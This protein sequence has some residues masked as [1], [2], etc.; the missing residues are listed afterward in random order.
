MSEFRPSRFEILPLVVK[1]LLIINILFFIAQNTIGNNPFFSITD[2]LALHHVQSPLFK[3]W[4]IITY[5]F[6]HAGIWHL[7]LNMFGL[8]MFGARLESMWGP[9]RFLTFYFLCGIGAAFLQL[10]S[11]W[12]EGRD[13]LTDL[14]YVK[15][16]LSFGNLY[17]YGSKYQN[18]PIINQKAAD[19]INGLAQNQ[20][21]GS[22]LNQ[23]FSY[24]QQQ[25][26]RMISGPTMG[27]SGSV[28]GLL[29]AFVYL[30]PNDVFYVNFFLPVKVK[31]LGLIYFGVEIFGALRS[32]PND[33]IAHW[34]HIGGGIVGFLLV[35][36]WNR[37]RRRFY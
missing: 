15:N 35:L 3:P 21:D 17:D 34:A 29:A 2:L 9:R 36:T 4:Q 10:A 11:L 32:G 25:T 14:A 28:F 27:A 20:H 6:L 30:Y 37:S 22:M 31:W 13:L 33:G 16:H 5:A 24:I 19:L 12:Y 26:L 18:T 8:W 1:N 23:A 7:A